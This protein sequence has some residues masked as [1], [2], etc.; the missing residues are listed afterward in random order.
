MVTTGSDTYQ[1]EVGERSVAVSADKM[2]VFYIGVDNPISVSAAG[3]PTSSLRVSASGGGAKVRKVNNSQYIVTVGT[4]SED[5]KVTIRGEGM[6]PTSKPFRAKRIPDPIAKLGRS[7]GGTIGSGEFRA[8]AGVLAI[9]ERFDF[10]VRCAIDRFE[11][12]Y[13]AKRQDAVL[14]KNS[15][16]RFTS[17]AKGLINKAKP[18]DN[19]FFRDVRAKC[20]GD[21]N[22]RELNSMVFTIK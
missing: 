22:T 13:V 20:P 10:D 19:Y 21:K 7:K 6:S 16:P 17:R 1:Y 4:P 8:Q 11:M 18:G 3:V 14:V 5:V 12:V 15:G 9:L 2:N